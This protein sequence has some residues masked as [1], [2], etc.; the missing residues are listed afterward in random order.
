MSTPLDIV[1]KNEAL[2]KQHEA[3]EKAAKKA[4]KQSAVAQQN[5]ER[6]TEVPQLAAA[7]LEVADKVRELLRTLDPDFTHYTSVYTHE[8]EDYAVW[9]IGVETL[10]D[11]H[12]LN[13]F[14]GI[15][16]GLY[17]TTILI[18]VPYGIKEEALTLEVLSSKTFTEVEAVH[19]LLTRKL[20]ELQSSIRVQAL[21]ERDRERDSQ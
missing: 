6:A 17:V 14:L 19:E 2:K 16:G 4:A 7:T 8:S 13:V 11:S 3:D 15:E 20:L 9:W 12:H 5:I 18:K 1:R 10:L 21:Q